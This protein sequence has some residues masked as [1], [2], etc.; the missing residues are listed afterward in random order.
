M[1]CFLLLYLLAIIVISNCHCSADPKG[2][3]IFIEAKLPSEDSQS[4]TMLFHKGIKDI[5]WAPVSYVGLSPEWN[6]ARQQA[7][8]GLMQWTMYAEKP[9]LLRTSFQRRGI[10]IKP[11]DSVSITYNS[12]GLDFS[13][14]G[15][16]GLRLQYQIEQVQKKLVKPTKLY[17]R[18]NSSEEFFKWNE[19]QNKRLELI[20]P[21]IDDF[22]NK[23][24]SAVYRMIKANAICEIEMERAESFMSLYRLA[25]RDLKTRT[26]INLNTV[27]DSTMSGQCAKWLQSISDFPFDVWYFY[28]LNQLQVLRKYSF[29]NT[30]DSL[31]NGKREWIYY[32][33]IK[34]NYQGLLRE[35]MQQ[36]LI[37]NE[38]IKKTG[39][40]DPATDMILKDYYS[41]PGFP[42]YRQWMK[43]Y[44]LGKREK[45]KKTRKG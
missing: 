25:H 32:S 8:D 28:K 39:F 24:D 37:A 36:F 16:E 31:D 45:Y 29:D 38:T 9:L 14:R 42:E 43:Q 33:A 41:Q 7:S 35:R 12:K 3:K 15:A 22:K 26:A 34:Q 17:L 1:K 4:D 6:S 23:I 40:D 27:Y 5:L 30:I 2:Q 20:M 18:L 19:Y 11:G 44:E 10:L 21:I 13:G